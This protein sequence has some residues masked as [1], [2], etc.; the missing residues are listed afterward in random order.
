M[1]TLIVTIIIIWVLCVG[2]WWVITKFVRTSDVGKIKSRLVGNTAEKK[3]E[4]SRREGPVLI[5][6]EDQYKDKIAMR[7][8]Q[9]YQLKDRLQT[10]LEQ[11]GLRWT[12]IKFAHTSLALFLLQTRRDVLR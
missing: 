7:L 2:L 11:A 10:L 12:V 9:K 5:Q 1:T 3:K 8:L 4:K 6:F